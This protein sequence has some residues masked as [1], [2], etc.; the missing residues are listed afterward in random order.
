M[1]QG[2]FAVRSQVV[3]YLLGNYPVQAGRSDGL[4]ELDCLL[5][6]ERIACPPARHNADPR[7]E[8]GGS[9]LGVHPRSRVWR[10]AVTDTAVGGYGYGGWR[11]R[12]RRLAVMPFWHHVG[13]CV[14]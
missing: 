1:D 11:S 13:S 8:I 3:E 9:S 5:P 4:E 6:R 14:C 7:Q 10:L 12:V 2:I